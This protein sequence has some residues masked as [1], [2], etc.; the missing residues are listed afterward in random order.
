MVATSVPEGRFQLHLINVARG[1]TLERAEAA[2][3]HALRPE[4]TAPAP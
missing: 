1:M 4:G 2:Q 3:V